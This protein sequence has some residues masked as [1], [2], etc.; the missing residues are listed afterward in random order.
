M[1]G[2]EAKMGSLYFADRVTKRNPYSEDGLYDESWVELSIDECAE[3]EMFT[4]KTEIFGFK[5]SKH[6]NGWQ[7]RAMDYIA[8][9]HLYRRKVIITALPKDYEEAKA[10]YTGHSPFD[11]FLRPYEPKV[12]VHST[13]P[14][15]YPAI[16]RE[17][18]LK[19]WQKVQAANGVRETAPIG[20]TLGDPSDFQEF[21]MLGSG[22]AP[23]IVVSSR[24]KGFVCMDSLCEYTPGGR[25]YF[26]VEQLAADGLL[27]RDGCHYKV[28]DELPI[29][30]A[31]FCGTLQNVEMRGQAITP[32]SFAQAADQVF[33]RHMGSVGV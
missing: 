20:L 24:Q 8:Y 31:L 29:S 14:G 22:V 26:D 30:H 1:K 11:R 12:L 23:E 2:S 16:C 32:D 25:F 9:H 6:C 17:G 15:A 13:T 18:V 21:V 27:V 28:K 10:V 4:G 5:L 33:K 3:Y 7:F 19:S